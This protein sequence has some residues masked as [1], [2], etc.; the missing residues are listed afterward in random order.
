[1]AQERMARELLAGEGSE[2]LVETALEGIR[3]RHAQHDEIRA[4]HRFEGCPARTDQDTPPLHPRLLSELD[5]RGMA[6]LYLHQGEAIR[7]TLAGEHVVVATATA[8][9]KSL[10]F[11]LPVLDAVLRQENA[12]ALYLYPTKALTQDQ[13]RSLVSWIDALDLRLTAGVYDGDT[14]PVLRRKLK[15]GGR[16]VLT[17]PDMLHRLDFAS[18]WRVGRSL[19]KLEICHRR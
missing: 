3:R 19:R 14:D 16:I 10:C 12:Y 18:P 5:S 8:S 15:R 6:P 4:L 9:G 11:H 13:H 1:M 17:N 2:D 7:R